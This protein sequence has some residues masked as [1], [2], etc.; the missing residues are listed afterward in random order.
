MCWWFGSERGIAFFH[1]DQQL[2]EQAAGFPEGTTIHSACPDGTVTTNST[3]TCQSSGEWTGEAPSCV[4][5]DPLFR[6]RALQQNLSSDDN[7]LISYQQNMLNSVFRISLACWLM[8]GLTT[9]F[10]LVAIVVFVICLRGQRQTLTKRALALGKELQGCKNDK[11]D[12][13]L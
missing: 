13:A 4:S 9:V 3:V 11:Y 8:F 6:N 10:I 7:Q 12:V 2:A 1:G 5:K